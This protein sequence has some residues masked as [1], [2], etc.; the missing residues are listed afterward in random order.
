M[1]VKALGQH[2]NPYKRCVISLG[3][4]KK[5]YI[6]ATQVIKPESTIKLNV[7]LH[8]QEHSLSCEVAALKMALNY[9]KIQ[10]KNLDLYMLDISI[11]PHLESL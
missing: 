4:G 5:I 3:I 11:F 8:K 6:K 9:K 7:K 10:T 1:L 2:G